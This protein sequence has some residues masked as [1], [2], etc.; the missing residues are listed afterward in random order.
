M[1]K[2][3]SV[4]E[5]EIDYPLGL[6]KVKIGSLRRTLTFAQVKREKN[7]RVSITFT[8]LTTKLAENIS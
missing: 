1:A 4:F 3:A 7:S 6:L 5:A 2:L 8:L